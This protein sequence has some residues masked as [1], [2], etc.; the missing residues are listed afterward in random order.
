V[1]DALRDPRPGGRREAPA[2]RGAAAPA[3]QSPREQQASFGTVLRDRNVFTFVLG[4]T[5]SQLGD[6][7]NHMALIGLIGSTSSVGSS[8]FALAT[9]A[10]IFT[11]PVVAFGPIAGV[12]VDRWNKRVTLIV[13]DVLRALLVASIPFAYQATHELIVV[14]AISFLVFLAG[15]FFNSAKMAIIP[16]LVGRDQ[17]LATN[18]VTNFVGRFATVIGIVGGGVIVGWS[19]WGRLGWRGYT[20]GFYLDAASYLISV[21]TLA[22]LV[23]RTLRVVGAP[24]RTQRDTLRGMSPEL[25][26]CEHGECDD[27]DS[28]ARVVT[29]IERSLAHDLVAAVRLIRRDRALRFVYSTVVLLAIIAASAYVVVVAAVQSVMGRGTTG[30]GFLG[31]TM[32]GGLIV[33][34]LLVGTLGTRFDRRTIVTAGCA[35]L[36]IVMT[37]CALFFQFKWLTPLA[38]LGGVLLAPV[39]VSQ[40]T[41]LHETSP[42]GARGVIFSAREL[43][44]SG[45]FML[46]ALVVGGAIA[47]MARAGVAEPYRMALFV[48]GAV[49]TVAALGLARLR[50]SLEGMHA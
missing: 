1:S 25:G 33:G 5:V 45:S 41:L 19:I 6:K 32:A 4:Q 36:G 42:E 2:D 35:L 11:L 48:L 14:Y 30:V 16:D 43:V 13:C 10:V 9:L 39:M 40:D 15:L 34:S 27:T 47:L 49:V 18:A 44:L 23:P 50:R 38:F 3:V 22:L 21:A 26:A 20:A 17:L 46:T 28:I 7:L 29:R 12:L 8:G 37:A 24:R 31:G